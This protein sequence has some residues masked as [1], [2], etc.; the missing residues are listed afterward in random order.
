MM[1]QTTT[2]WQAEATER[3]TTAAAAEGATA[4]AAAA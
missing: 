1:L 3:T 2:E 4:E